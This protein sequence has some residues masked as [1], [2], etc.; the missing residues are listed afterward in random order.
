MRAFVIL[1]VA[2]AAPGAQAAISRS[3]ALVL[4]DVDD[5]PKCARGECV[6]RRIRPLD[7]DDPKLARGLRRQ[8]VAPAIEASY[9]FLQIADPYG[10]SL[11]FHLVELDGFPISRI[12]RLGVSLVGGAAP[13]YDAWMFMV[14]LSAGVQYPA[15]V[16][17][18]LDLRISAGVLGAEIIDRK[19]VSYAYMPSLEGGI[20]VYIASRFHLTAAVGWAHPVYGGVD[21]K[22]VEQQIAAG[23]KP[24]YE[25]KPFALDTVTVRIGLGF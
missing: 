15:R 21:A 2:L 24:R 11:P 22:L 13:R 10:G 20:S 6:P 19:V 3:A 1:L 12:F 8:H 7:E 16:T 4:A 18:F 25:V 14:G 9:R 23:I 17:P 5:D